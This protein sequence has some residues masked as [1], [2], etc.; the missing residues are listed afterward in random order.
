VPQTALHV[1]LKKSIWELNTCSSGVQQQTVWCNLFTGF[2][3][4]FSLCIVETSTATN[5]LTL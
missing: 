2:W 3:K 4:V 5:N 1:F